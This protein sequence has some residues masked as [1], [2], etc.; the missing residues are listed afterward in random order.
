MMSPHS[1]PITKL[2]VVKIRDVIHVENVFFALRHPPGRMPR[3]CRTP[4]YKTHFGK[5]SY[6]YNSGLKIIFNDLKN[7]VSI[8]TGAGRGAAG[9]QVPHV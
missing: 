6:F 4:N 1:T 9:S 2:S 8:V 5:G 3:N 7:L